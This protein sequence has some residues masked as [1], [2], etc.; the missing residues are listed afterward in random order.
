MKTNFNWKK[1]LSTLIVVIIASL[2]MAVSINT[3]CNAGELFP[4]GVTGLTILV[5][6]MFKLFTGIDLPYS[7]VNILLNAVPVYIGFKFI[8]KKFTLYSCL[9]IVFTAL[10]TDF[11]PNYKITEDMLLISIFGGIVQGLGISMCLLKDTTSGGTDFIAIYFSEKKHID[12]WNLVLGFNVVVLVIAG[13]MFGWEKALYSIIFQYVTTKVIQ[14]TFH[15]YDKE[16]LLIVTTKPREICELIYNE[17]N[18]AATILPCEGAY[19]RRQ[20]SIVYSVV[21]QDEYSKVIRL[22]HDIDSS[23]FI[24]TLKTETLIGNFYQRPY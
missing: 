13:F 14:L 12:S 20:M 6:R 15:R 2:T 9:V 5:I 3:F 8:A 17:A 23:A 4:G 18:H 22:V 7:V 1:E 24:N 11:L 10:F 16:T 21:S 19:S